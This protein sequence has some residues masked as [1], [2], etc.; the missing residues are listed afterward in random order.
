MLRTFAAWTFR[1]WTFR[2]LTLASSLPIVS[3]QIV[4]IGEIS[5]VTVSTTL[6]NVLAYYWY[7]DGCYVGKTSEPTKTF[8][9][10]TGEQFRLEVIPSTD[11]NFDPIANAPAGYPS[12]RT[13]WWIRSLDTA[14]AG[15]R[16]EQ[17]EGSGDWTSLAMI[18]TTTEAWD[19]F[20]LTDQLKDLTEYSWRITPLDAGGL[21][22]TPIVVGPELIVRTP[23]APN[24][25]AEFDPGTET[26]E[27]AVIISL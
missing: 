24:F 11:A 7:F 26:V 19:Y 4:R 22:G 16:V 1:A 8:H 27:F 25:S 6:E 17:R 18:P 15:Y 3:Y 12:R 21:A 10:P 5:E 23:D 14:A 2:S 9:I 13:L 20:L